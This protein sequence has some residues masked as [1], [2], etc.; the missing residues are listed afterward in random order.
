M[1][2]SNLTSSGCLPRIAFRVY[3][4]PSVVTPAFAKNIEPNQPDSALPGKTAQPKK[5]VFLVLFSYLNN[6]VESACSADIWT[7]ITLYH[8]ST[9]P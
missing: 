7:I 8:C 5:P 9:G 6:E 1:D 3:P 2:R 4:C